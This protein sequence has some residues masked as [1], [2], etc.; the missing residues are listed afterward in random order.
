MLHKYI[1]TKDGYILDIYRIPGPKDEC[2]ADG[3]RNA[4]EL[5]RAPILLLHGVASSSEGYILNGPDLS[6]GLIL[7][8]TGRYD[9]WFLNV[10]GN[11]YSRHH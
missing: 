4:K 9:L 10:R 3:I 5:N 6:P 2:L 8:D 11:T 1:E 7:A